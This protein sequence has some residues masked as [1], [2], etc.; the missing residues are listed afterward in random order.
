MRMK[1]QEKSELAVWYGCDTCG[2]M[3]SKH[4]GLVLQPRPWNTLKYWS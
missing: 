3:E 1:N 4:R 2:V